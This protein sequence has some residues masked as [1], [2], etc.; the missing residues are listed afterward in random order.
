MVSF[1]QPLPVVHQNYLLV[2]RF[3]YT[4]R[5]IKPCLIFNVFLF[6]ESL[7]TLEFLIAMSTRLF[8]QVIFPSARSLLGTTGLLI[9]KFEILNSGSKLI[10]HVEI[11]FKG[12]LFMKITTTCLIRTT[13]LLSLARMSTP[14]A[15]SGPHGY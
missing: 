13:R 10:L 3:K 11:D 15:Y 6:S 2:N 9:F 8:F 1:E 4:Y 5:S 12:P 7:L 14:H